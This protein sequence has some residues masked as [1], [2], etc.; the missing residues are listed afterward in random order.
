MEKY[1][2]LHM[3]LGYFS[4]TV[5]FHFPNQIEFFKMLLHNSFLKQYR[6]L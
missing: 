2:F 1:L 3:R 5:K 6:D 4:G